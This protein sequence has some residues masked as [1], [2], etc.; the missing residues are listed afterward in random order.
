MAHTVD[1]RRLA[2]AL[3]RELSRF[4]ETHPRSRALAERAREH[5]HDGVP[6]SWMV[7]WAGAFPVFV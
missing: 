4:R 6:M 1:R 2:T 3:E 7:R 5:L